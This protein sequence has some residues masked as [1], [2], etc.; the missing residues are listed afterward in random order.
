MR[1]FDKEQEQDAVSLSSLRYSL[2]KFWLRYHPCLGLMFNGWKIYG[3]L[4]EI[5]PHLYLRNI[6]PD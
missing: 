1:R 2:S 6:L 4:S 5:A 3:V